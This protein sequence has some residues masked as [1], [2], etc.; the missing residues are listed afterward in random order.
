MEAF[1]ALAATAG[2][3][4]HLRWAAVESFHEGAARRTTLSGLHAK[5][6][7]IS[8]QRSMAVPPLFGYANRP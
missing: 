2:T 7:T 1:H 4:S 6:E 8:C 5:A 3:S